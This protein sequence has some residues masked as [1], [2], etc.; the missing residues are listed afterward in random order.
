MDVDEAS[1]SVVV[2]IQKKWNAPVSP[3]SPDMTPEVR[4]Q[5]LSF[6]VDAFLP[7]PSHGLDRGNIIDLLPSMLGQ[8][9]VLDN[10]I[11]ALCS[12]FIGK[13]Y[14]DEALKQDA[15]RLYTI[16]LQGL[17]RSIQKVAVPPDDTLYATVV[18][19]YY[20]VSSHRLN[21]EHGC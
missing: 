4:S 18:L 9:P 16:T 19:G 11:T 20:E 5:F 1:K 2:A 17:L 14:K 21:C 10:A 12:L 3:S 8:S 7:A 13:T 15:L 6:F